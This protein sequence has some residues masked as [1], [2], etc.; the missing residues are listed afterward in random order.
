[1]DK[2]PDFCLHEYKVN[3]KPRAKVLTIYRW[4]DL[5]KNDN[6]QELKYKLR[7]KD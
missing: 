7:A 4:K 5:S 6:F 2:R 1:M 3:D